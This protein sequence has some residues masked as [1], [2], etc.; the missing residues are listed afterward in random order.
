VEPEGRGWWNDWQLSG[1]LLLSRHYC[2]EGLRT[3]G[4]SWIADLEALEKKKTGATFDKFA[5]ARN[6]W[7]GGLGQ[8]N[9]DVSRPEE[10]INRRCPFQPKVRQVEPET[11]D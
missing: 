4:Y 2:Q 9:T 3:A 6:C 8:V 5:P 11:S 7:G 1:N 10:W